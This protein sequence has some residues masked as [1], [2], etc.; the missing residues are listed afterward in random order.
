[1]FHHKEM[2]ISLLS[3]DWLIDKPLSEDNTLIRPFQAFL[4]NTASCPND[5][6]GHGKTFVVKIAHDDDEAVVFLAQQVIDWNF[7]VVVLNKGR[8]GSRRVSVSSQ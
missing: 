3:N 5:T 2:Y 8:T 1:M 4:H 6:T 7:D